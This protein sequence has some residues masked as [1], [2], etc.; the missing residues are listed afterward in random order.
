MVEML[1]ENKFSKFF[2]E[3]LDYKADIL[4]LLPKNT[5]YLIV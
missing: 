3:K 5:A 4:T 2:S 1:R